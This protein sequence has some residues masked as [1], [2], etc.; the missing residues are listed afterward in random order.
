TAPTVQGCPIASAPFGAQPIL[1]SG[2]GVSATMIH[3]H[4]CP[5]EQPCCPAGA[6]GSHDGAPSSPT[7]AV[8]PSPPPLAPRPPL[9]PPPPPPQRPPRPSPPPPPRR[10][11]GPP[12]PPA[13]RGAAGAPT[14]PTAGVAARC[15]SGRA[16]AI[17][18]L[19]PR[20]VGLAG[21]AARA[22]RGPD[23]GNGL[24]R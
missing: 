16:A 11:A 18:R 7:S 6:S 19:V 14:P 12:P 2:S 13:P 4:F 15:T 21:L 9:P 10:P 17:T 23:A 3:V 5:A 1:P 8:A 22:S 20:P 24:S